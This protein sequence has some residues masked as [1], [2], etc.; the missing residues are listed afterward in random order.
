MRYGV[1]RSRSVGAFAKKAV[2]DAVAV[3]RM[4]LALFIGK[5]KASGRRQAGL[6]R[7]PGLGE[8]ALR[9]ERKGENKGGDEAHLAHAAYLGRSRAASNRRRRGSAPLGRI[10]RRSRRLG[11]LGLALDGRGTLFAV[12]EPDVVDGVLDARES[13]TGR[14]HP[15]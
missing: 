8:Q 12:G 3:R 9:C 11:G 10:G 4:T 7:P 15:A 6:G 1:G 13:R 2:H 5:A 14:E